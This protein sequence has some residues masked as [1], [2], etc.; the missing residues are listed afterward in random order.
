MRATL[1]HFRLPAA[2]CLRAISGRLALV[3]AMVVVGTGLMPGPAVLDMVAPAYAQN[4]P[5]PSEPVC[6]YCHGK[7]CIHCQGVPPVD[8]SGDSDPILLPDDP[9]PILTPSPAPAPVL[10][11]QQ[12]FE[13]NKEALLQTFQ[14]P[15]GLAEDSSDTAT[16]SLPGTPV[17][18]ADGGFGEGP[19]P[20]GLTESEWK[21]AAD[22]QQQLDA[23][24]AHWPLSASEIALADKLEAQR[25]R[26]WKKAISV[27]GLTAE[28]R[29]RFRLKLHTLNANSVP[30]P[31]I[32]QE[33]SKQWQRVPELQSSPGQEKTPA[34][35]SNPVATWLVGEFGVGQAQSAVES[36]GEEWADRILDEHSY[37]DFLGVAKIAV[38]YKEGGASGAV[39][40]GLNYLVGKIPIPQASLAVEGGRQYAN[41]AFQAENRFMTAAM[42]G[43]GGEFDKDQFWSSFNADLNV[44]QKAVVGWVGYGAE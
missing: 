40:E 6:G 36:G 44:W 31:S 41:V 8:D 19:V 33:T 10:T 30:V 38:A 24:Y 2:G 1:S 11:P 35:S 39:T 9:D 20:Q 34:P 21:E 7:G 25:D 4:I 12:V 13:Q 18:C 3:A 23:L 32:N 22:A 5:E 43:A 29:E 16:V 26:L 27:P 15:A 42:E 14:M 37:G 28:E 17:V